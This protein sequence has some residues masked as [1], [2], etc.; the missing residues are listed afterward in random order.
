[1]MVRSQAVVMAIATTTETWRAGDRSFRA[2]LSE[3]QF[4]SSEFGRTEVRGQI[5]VVVLG[6]APQAQL[7]IGTTIELR[8]TLVATE[9][10]DDA[11][12][13]FFAES[14]PT[15]LEEPPWHLAWAA[16]LRSS[17]LSAST[18][19]PGDGG[20]L[21]AG[22]AIGD[23]S[24][25]TDRLDAAM[26]ISSLSHLTAVSGANCAIVV[27]LIMLGG[28]ALGV[29][30]LVRVAA[31][32]VVLLG[33]VVLV[34]PE[35]SVVR[36]A[37]MATLV[38]L[39]L[40][41]GSPV[42][43]MPIL[44]LAVLILLIADPW[45]ARDYGFAL[46]VLA[47]AG[48]LLLS[49]PIAGALNSWMPRW[50]AVVIAVPVSAQLACQPV[51][52][53]LDPTL[54]SYG[55]IANLLAAPA[56]PVA[57]VVGLLA[58]LCLALLPPVG[59][60]L[61]WLAWLPAAWIAGVA[62]FLA[63]LP[64]ARLPWLAGVPG[65]VLLAAVTALAVLVVVGRGRWRRPVALGLAVAS[66]AYLGLVGGSR[67]NILLSRPA[68]WQIAA[69][70][71]GQGDAML[72][73]SRGVTALIDTG[74]D[75]AL[76]SACFGELGIT[77]IDLLVL[78]HFDRDHVGGAEA[79]FGMVDTV[80][81]GPGDDGADRALL[82]R[83]AETGASVLQPWR[84]STGT[85]GDLRWSVLWPAP[86]AGTGGDTGS[87]SPMVRGG[88]EVGN[89]S[90]LVI[91]FR[92]IGDCASGCLSSLFLGDLGQ[93]A[94]EAVMRTHSLKP[95]DVVKVSHHGSADQ[96]SRLYERVAGTVGLIGVG[97][98][99]SYGHPTTELLSTLQGAGTVP[100]RT[101]TDGMILL[102]PGVEPG[103]ITVWTER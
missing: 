3:L 75:P 29:G 46:S 55:V 66:V 77:H 28:A 73:R 101:D 93:E 2:E 47:T 21:M 67:A 79:V 30:R 37:V 6:G 102:A 95:V 86:A 35:P 70:E 33:F 94:Q 38:L 80:I 64:G 76:L 40:S 54:P 10:G 13:L 20:D 98:E 15:L 56:A 91:E 45:L 60:A 59:I 100:F 92:G 23:T 51:I 43:G 39:A 50:L 49:G 87:G 25:V 27:G 52:I 17:F 14:A 85:L 58:C 88:F 16:T 63:A 26:K 82:R 61:C 1:E 11:S 32:V 41:R 48:L 84:G 62:G 69:C 97:A 90:S 99:N 57:T 31:S 4:T 44:S 71:I 72:V 22:L 53:L 24:A 36:A 19:L 78:T 96:S 65:A 7:E 42:G 5:P 8:G 89:D 9:A 74:E 83:L 103:T 12:A 81:A 68:G 34:T 18:T